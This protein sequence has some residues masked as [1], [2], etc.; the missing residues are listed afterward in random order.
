MIDFFKMPQAI[1]RRMNEANL[2]A[3]RRMGEDIAR[4]GSLNNYRDAQLISIRMTGESVEA[5]TRE[6]SKASG[7]TE[8][9]IE[10]L[11]LSAKMLTYECGIR[12]LADFL[13]GDTYFKT[14]R[15]EHNLDRARTQ[16]K[17]C[18][19]IDNKMEEMKAVVKE[20]CKR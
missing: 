9:E 8:K 11:P 3:L 1:A 12:F 7:M 19:D 15:E 10:L 4:I 20:C 13:N 17:I 2:Y 5:I 18:R 16:F 14:T 6:L